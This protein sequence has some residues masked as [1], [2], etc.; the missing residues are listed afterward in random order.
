[1]KKKVLFSAVVLWAASSAFAQGNG[2]AGITEATNMVTSYFD[3][4]TKLIYAIGAVVG[5]IGGV[6][7]YG[8]FTLRA[9]L[10]PVKRRLRGSVRVSS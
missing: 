10:T 3:P 6:K 2:M 9:T 7:V 4:A 5:L 8:K 1:M